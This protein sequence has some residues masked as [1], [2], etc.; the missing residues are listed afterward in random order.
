[1]VSFYKISDQKG[2]V[3]L[4]RGQGFQR[5][6]PQEQPCGKWTR[7]SRRAAAIWH[8][9]IVMDVEFWSSLELL[10]QPQ[11]AGDSYLTHI[12]PWSSIGVTKRP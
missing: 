7:A 9:R 4:K 3:A 2:V 11:R 10:I 1:M 12:K 8:P 5:K 6:G